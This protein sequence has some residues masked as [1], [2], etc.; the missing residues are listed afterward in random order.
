MPDGG[1]VAAGDLIR[2]LE[3]VD[4]VARRTGST[5]EAVRDIERRALNEAPAPA[6]TRRPMPLDEFARRA[7]KIRLARN[8]RLGAPLCRDPAWDILLDLFAS[9]GGEPMAI[10]SLCFDAGVPPT[11]AL[12]H[13]Q[14]LAQAGLVTRTA[15]KSDHRRILVD[16]TEQGAERVAGLL[17]DMRALMD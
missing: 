10:S 6:G 1:A 16:L 11:T 9:R 3:L 2:L 8:R 7:R 4:I 13:V 14:N 5:A 17:R 15:D 12:R